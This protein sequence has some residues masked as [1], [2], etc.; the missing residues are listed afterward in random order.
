MYNIA[1]R[2]R[3]LELITVVNRLLRRS[4]LPSYLLPHILAYLGTP[5]RVSWYAIACA[6][7]QSL[8]VTDRHS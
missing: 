7:K 1:E 6:Q 3:M 2:E 4:G 5:L 8:T